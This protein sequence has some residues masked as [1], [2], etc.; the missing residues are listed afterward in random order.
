[1]QTGLVVA[2]LYLREMC[3]DLYGQMTLS[4]VSDEETFGPWGARYLF[5]HHPQ[6]I[7]DCCLNAEPSSPLTL[8]FG[9]K[10]KLWLKFRVRTLG[11]H[12]AYTHMSRS[13]TGIAAEV[14]SELA[15]LSDLPVPRV[16]NIAT[17]LDQAAGGHR[18]RLWKGRLNNPAG[19]DRQSGPH[20]RWAQGQHGRGRV[21]FRG[22]YPP[23]CGSDRAGHPRG[24]GSDRRR[25]SR[26]QLRG[27]HL[28]SS[29][30]E[31]P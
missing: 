8:R 11:A 27:R 26:G 1:G 15:H 22:G 7:G 18:P 10:G 12:G 2:L 5:E 17:T 28:R 6:I 13:A 19:R 16:S 21:R 30:L 29:E 25:T 23:A 24:G 31:R 9:E 20:S 14:I 3:E 4:V